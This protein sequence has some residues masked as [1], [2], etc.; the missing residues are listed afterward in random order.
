MAVS[1]PSSRNACR[2]V[3]NTGLRTGRGFT[4]A[5]NDVKRSSH[6]QAG[7]CPNIGSGGEPK[8]LDEKEMLELSDD[9]AMGFP[10]SWSD[11]CDPMRWRLGA[12]NASATRFHGSPAPAHGDGIILAAQYGAQMT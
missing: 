11:Y 7:E 2:R 12:E 3:G 5:V 8:D 10:A 6:G 1:S 9:N 4:S